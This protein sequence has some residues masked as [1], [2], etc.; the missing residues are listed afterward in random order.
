MMQSK[1]IL[2]TCLCMVFFLSLCMG[3]L[4]HASSK[5]RE[6]ENISVSDLTI[7][8]IIIEFSDFSEDKTEW[9]KMARDLIFLK[10][11]DRFSAAK[12][13]ES[14]D[15][16]KLSERFR[17]INVDSIKEEGERIKLLFH[18]TPFRLIKNIKISGGHPLFERQIL[19][20]MKVYTGDAFI[21][22]EVKKQA[23]LIEKLF[24]RQGFPV[25]IVNVKAREDKDDGFFIIQVNIEKG[26]YFTL[27][28]LEITGNRA[29]S[30]TKLKLKMHSWRV[31]LLPGSSRRFI[32]EDLKKDIRNLTEYYW[33]KKYPDVRIDFKIEK[34]SQAKSVSVFINID[35]GPRYDIEFVGNGE[36]WDSTLKKDLIL[37]NKG[38][39]NDLG[40]KKS[41]RK[42]KERYKMAGY[43]KT[44]VKIEE[45]TNTGKHE[46]IRAL[47]FVINEGPCSIVNSIEITGNRAFDYEKLE[48]QML[49][50]LPGFL[51]KGSFVP[52]TFEQDLNAVKSLYIRE[53]YM[54]T[55]VREELTW[56]E[57]KSN[58]SINL[59]IEEGPQTLV[60]SMKITGI[61]V[62]S[63]EEAHEAIQMKK[64][65][66]FRKYMI[67][68][69]EN[70]LSALV[71]EKGHPH[72][73]VKGDVSISRDRSK[74]DV[75]YTVDE[76]QYVVMRH[77]YYK[78]NLRTKDKILQN[79]LEIEPGAPFSLVDMVKEQR[80]IRNLDIF[81]SVQFKTVGLKEK[82]EEVNLFVE[83]EEK[84]PYFI[85]AGGGYETEKGLFVNARA[86]DHNIF[87]ANK[88]GWLEGEV[89]QIG[90]RGELGIREPRILGS[91]I[92]AAFGLFSERREG[93]NQDF[94]T[95]TYGS[96]LSFTRKWFQRLTTGL[97]FR[98]EERDQF[99]RGLS[100]EKR[101]LS[102]YDPDEFKPRTIF[103]TSPAISYDTR[104]SFVRPK[105]GTLSSFSLDISNGLSS[106]LDD[107][108][109]YRIDLRL[110][111]S[112]LSQLT[113][114]FLGRAG[115][116]TPFGETE[117]VPDDQLFFLGGTSDVR[118]FDEN[119][120][121]FDINND[122]VGGST[123]VVGSI[124]ARI[125]LGNNFELTAF[126]DTGSVTDTSNEIGSDQL[127]SS[128]GGGL[129]YITPIGAIGFLY[130]VKL[131]RK[132]GESPGRLHFSLGYTF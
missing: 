47:R 20:T 79:E 1:E 69:D 25:P 91:R 49:I 114:A 62:V 57:D 34:D 6:P 65:K 52:E 38:N 117:R 11:G 53:G 108:L 13:Q 73:K 92:S 86:G 37:F 130:G 85:E 95:V 50:R 59:E 127:R 67:R 83:I 63:Q 7:S 70:A 126:Y 64:G 82:E 44:R 68:S 124:E 84:K 15:I 71:S 16:L 23:S 30:R 36:F 106:P 54:D 74:A 21:E 8:G 88:D 24:Q 39:K 10:E 19:N 31:L 123:A 72:V 101:Y 107:F 99:S 9:I 100:E 90:Y 5:E 27:K 40:L 111:V 125:D 43:L 76:G 58:V 97:S 48:K 29:F 26:P 55:K 46:T 60:S 93:F 35:E 80:N 14:L 112:P 4:G 132:E 51:E 120:L 102:D 129:R 87:G 17:E 131:D 2:H 22:E 105:R 18:L 98:F 116:I 78:G 89:S 41:V 77:V 103:V 32:E 75:V 118:G 66:P 128:V 109:R 122:P 113:F 3:F 42:I 119:L 96:S 94:G 28:R 45:E 61:T 121:R 115:H 104:D 81:N 12:L 33:K 110:Y 56:S